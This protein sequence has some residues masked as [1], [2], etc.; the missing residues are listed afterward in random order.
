[1]TAYTPSALDKVRIPGQITLGIELPLDNDWSPSGEARRLADGRP[2]G[3]PDLT[4]H[5]ELVR[6]V[7]G[8]GFAA[9]WMRDV[10]VFDS[11]RMGDA[12]SV[13]EVFSHL[14]FLAGITRNVALGTAAVVLPIRHP[15]MI[16]KAAASVDA[17]SG[18]RLIL[19]VASGD[20]PIEYPLLGL[21]FETRGE[22]FREAVAY[23]R[24]AWMPGGLP[25]GGGAREPS[26]DLLPRPVRGAIP[27][28]VAGQAQQSDDWIS[29]NM[30]GR[31]VYPGTLERLTAQAGA[32]KVAKGEGGAFISAFHLDLAE[33]PG[34]P[35][36]PFRFGGRAGRNAFID[37]L[38]QLREVGVDHLAVLLRRSRRPVDEVLDELAGDVLP[39]LGSL[40]IRAAA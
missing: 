14:G 1:M 18:G 22:R 29:A 15:M 4:R 27:L 9:V 34:E 28:V 38:E 26:L 39:Q 11:A 5:A 30:D 24:T 19:G 16:A 13:Y 8:Q 7:D 31:F 33:D 2:A 20:R 17:L 37:H 40:P 21:D 36:Q 25:I 32:W 10:P 6:K 12:G 3:V 35:L 23:M